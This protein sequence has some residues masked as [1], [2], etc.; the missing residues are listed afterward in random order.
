[1]LNDR[2]EIGSQLSDTSCTSQTTSFL[3]LIVV[4]LLAMVFPARRKLSIF[5]VTIEYSTIRPGSWLSS[6]SCS[7]P[8]LTS[9]TLLAPLML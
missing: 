3:A 5:T 7:S 9:A 6:N 1:M 8:R 4:L 2:P